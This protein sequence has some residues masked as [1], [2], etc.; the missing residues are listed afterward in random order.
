KTFE[1][2]WDILRAHAF[3]CVTHCHFHAGTCSPRIDFDLPS[4]RCVSQRIADQIIE[5]TANCLCI[6]EDRVNIWIDLAFKLYFMFQCKVRETFKCIGDEIADRG[7][8]ALKWKPTG[9][10][11]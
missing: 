9:I 3:A 4:A 11:L 2:M 7:V 8:R 6:H 1:D 5:H 10:Q